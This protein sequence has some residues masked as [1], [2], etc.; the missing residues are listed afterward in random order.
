LVLLLVNPYLQSVAY[1]GLRLQIQARA[2]GAASS[3]HLP[4][5]SHLLNYTQP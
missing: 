4:S 3:K 2:P 1:I 5:T